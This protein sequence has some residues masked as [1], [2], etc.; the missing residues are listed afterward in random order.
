MHADENL[1]LY[2]TESHD[3]TEILLA[4]ALNTINPNPIQGRIHG[5]GG[6][7]PG[8]PPQKIEKKV[9]FGQKR[10]FFTQKNR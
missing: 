7:P 8:G 2:K 1:Y 5:G 6:G 4:V 9:F 3:I 10:E